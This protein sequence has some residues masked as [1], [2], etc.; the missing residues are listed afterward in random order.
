[1][2][3]KYAHLSGKAQSLHCS[4]NACL[5]NTHTHTLSF[6]LSLFHTHIHSHSLSLSHT[7]THSHT[8]TYIQAKMHA[9]THRQTDRQTY[10][11]TH[12]HSPTHTHTHSHIHINT[13]THTHTLYTQM[14]T[15][16]QTQTLVVQIVIKLFGQLQVKGNLRILQNLV[17][18]WLIE[19]PS[20]MTSS[21]CGSTRYLSQ[22]ILKGEVSLY[23]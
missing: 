15:F 11:P 19:N 13:G 20:F 4:E 6:S 22:G 9:H 12:T 7:H 21:S 14:H 18:I 23:H 17:K 2:V 10:T 5:V 8:H 16:I 3:C 1:M